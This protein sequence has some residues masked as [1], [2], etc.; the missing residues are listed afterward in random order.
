[1]ISS[2]NYRIG[3]FTLERDQGRILRDGLPLR[4]WSRRRYD[5]LIVLVDAHGSVVSYDTL[6]QQ[7]WDGRNVSTHTITKTAND[8][9]KM[10]GEYGD[11]I[12][13]QPGQGYYFQSLSSAVNNVSLELTELTLYE[14]ALDEFKKRSLESLQKA[15]KHFRSV[16][17]TNPDFAP[18][19]LGVANCLILLGH[20]AFPIFKSTELLPEARVSI[21]K[22]LQFGQDRE[23]NAA[24][25]EAL[26]RLQLM[27]EW[28]VRGAEENF[29]KAR[30]VDEKHAAAYQ[31]LAHIYLITY[32]WKESIDA[33]TMARMQNPASPMIHGTAGWHRHFMGRGEEA[34]RICSEVTELYPQFPAGHAML[35]ISLESIGAFDDAIKAYQT[36]WSLESSP[37][38]LAGLGHAYGTCGKPGKARA[39]LKQLEAMA[40]ER[41]VS[42]LFFALIHTGLGEFDVAVKKLEAACGERADWMIYLGVEPR[43]R[44]L[45]RYKR[46]QALLNKVGVR[47]K[48]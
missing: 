20:A 43:W 37:V 11:C 24:A 23:T 15:L 28:D 40:N 35:G 38:A 27:Y 41:P 6:I 17:D 9:K 33:I 25:W 34:V 13:N 46:F 18:A 36:S 19:H 45:H 14:L 32:R 3:P 7:V 47:L 21:D 4:Q 42:S 26:G 10:L 22:T 48:P 12:R 29:K 39:I 44:P 31:G 16:R 8:L 30:A 2:G 1:M 5:L